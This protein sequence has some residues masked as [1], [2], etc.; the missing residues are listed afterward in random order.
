[1]LVENRPIIDCDSGLITVATYPL[2]EFLTKNLKSLK[3]FF[4][5]VFHHRTSIKGRLP[6][7]AFFH[8]RLSLIKG[9]RS[10]YIP[11]ECASEES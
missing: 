9:Q 1:M 6:S 5:G 7:K 4:Q 8:R 10:K 11:E 2:V 3:I